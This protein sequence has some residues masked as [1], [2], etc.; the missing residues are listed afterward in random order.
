MS[1][2]AVEAV[3]D[4][5]RVL[6]VVAHPDDIDFG[7]AG[8]VAAW[9]AAGVEVSYCIITDGDAGGFDPEVPRPE[10]GGIRQQEQRK[11]AGVL[12]V[13]DIA[14]LGYPDGRLTVTLQLR[15]DI[16]R[17]IRQVRPDRVVTQSPT[18]DLHSMYGS[19]PD[20]LAAGEATL[21]AVYPDA[22]NQ[23]AHPELA[24]AEGLAAHT[25]GQTWVMCNNARAEHYVDVTDTIDLKI[26]A[27]REHVSQ[28]AHMDLDKLM[29]GWSRRQ[30]SAAGWPDGRL[31]EGY[32]V[33]DTR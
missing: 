31:A 11:A 26:A 15:R 21:C 28:T 5:Q 7:C 12:G 33:L 23:W 8:S 10:I 19:H 22:R 2:L 25:V 3:Q 16:A 4:V 18:R 30:A 29:R 27:L 9:T 20:H 13:S 32:L 24:T 14:F 17:V 6:V 1:S